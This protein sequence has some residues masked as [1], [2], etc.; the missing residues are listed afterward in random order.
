MKNAVK[1]NESQL[2]KVV[3]ES[4]KK[5][6]KEYNEEGQVGYIQHS[7]FKDLWDLYCQIRD[8]N[9]ADPFDYN[10]SSWKEAYRQLHGF[11]GDVADYIYELA[12]SDESDEQ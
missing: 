3:A 1:L 12:I 5:V 7:E 2:K 11:L 9:N 8:V 4:V 10:A 6:L